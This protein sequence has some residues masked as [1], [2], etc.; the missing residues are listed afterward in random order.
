MIFQKYLP[1]VLFP[2]DLNN[3]TFDNI[4]KLNN[5]SI[6]PNKLFTNEKYYCSN[7]FSH[8]VNFKTIC[9]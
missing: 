5:F 3:K 9:F 2:I 7:L 4:I 8:G 6:K 1:L